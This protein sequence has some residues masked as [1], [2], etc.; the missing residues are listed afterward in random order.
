V[1]WG[2]YEHIKS[3]TGFVLSCSP[4]PF[5]RLHHQVGFA[6]SLDGVAGRRTS[7]E[8]KQILFARLANGGSGGLNFGHIEFHHLWRRPPTR[9]HHGTRHKG[10]VLNTF[11]I[12][13]NITDSIPSLHTHWQSL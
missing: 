11:G 8:A 2:Q 10:L 12:R 5:G 7:P 1:Q 13:A 4:R 9:V 6:L 3:A